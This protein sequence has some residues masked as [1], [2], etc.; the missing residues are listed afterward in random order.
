MQANIPRM[1]SGLM[2]VWCISVPTSTSAVNSGCCANL[3]QHI[4][5]MVDHKWGCHG[6]CHEMSHLVNFKYQIEPWQPSFSVPESICRHSIYSAGL[7]RAKFTDSISPAVYMNV[8]HV[9]SYVLVRVPNCPATLPLCA[10]QDDIISFFET[11]CNTSL[12]H[13]ITRKP[14]ET[15]YTSVLFPGDFMCSWAFSHSHGSQV[16]NGGRTFRVPL[17]SA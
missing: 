6:D 8:V 10:D 9:W 2:W 16:I 5:K 7:D 1:P 14:E 17:V 3:P 4:T 15:V 13:D 11:R 12:L